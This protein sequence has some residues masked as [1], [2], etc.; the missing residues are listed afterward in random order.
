M[1]K[2]WML[3]L[4]GGGIGALARET[5]MLVVATPNALAGF[6]MPIFVANMT[7]AFL[8]GLASGLAAKGGIVTNKWKT[9]Y[10]NR[11]HGWV[12]DL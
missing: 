2:Q 12:V 8:I 11:H 9:V 7:A 1:Y 10:L 3:V 5:L 4:I 6:N